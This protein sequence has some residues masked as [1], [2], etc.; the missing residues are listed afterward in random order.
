MEE[1]ENALNKFLEPWKHRDEVIGFLVC[2]SYI[3]GNPSKRSDIDLHII[4]SDNTEWRERG[5]NFINGYH[6][7]YFVNPP[8]QIRA[9]FKQSHRTNK[10]DSQ[11]QFV[12]GKILSD[13]TGSIAQLKKEAGD[14]LGKQFNGFDDISLILQKYVLWDIL[15]N[16]QDIYEKK[17]KSFRYAYYSGLREVLKF[18]SKYIGWEIY[19]PER[20]FELL[21]DPVVQKKYLQSEYPDP[22]FRDLFIKC[23]T[24]VKE[25]EML[26]CFEELV[27]YVF[28]HSEGFE[29]DGW[30]VRTPLGLE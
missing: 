22:V 26:E 24:F 23:I 29:I 6:I 16:L 20:I 9:Y 27:D 14:W 2:G 25:S 15:D 11:T 12:T 8:K 30:V 1:W 28:K 17:S 18:Y 21:S 13:K 5:S 4:T 3:T 10:L 7:E 19:S